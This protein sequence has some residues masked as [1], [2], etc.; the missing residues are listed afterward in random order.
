MMIKDSDLIDDR[1]LESIIWVKKSLKKTFVSLIV[2]FL[3]L[4]IVFPIEKALAGGGFN[5]LVKDVFPKGTMSN[6]TSSAI[7]KEQS[8]GHYIGGSAVIKAPANPPLRPIRARAPSCKLGGM[9]CGAQFE[10]MG[11]ALSLIK[12]QE[13]INYLK[14]LPANAATYGGMMAIKTLCPQCQDLLEYLDAKADELNSISFDH[15]KMNQALIDPLFPKE[16]AKKVALKQSDMLLKGEGQDQGSIQKESKKGDLGQLHQEL[17]SQLGENYNIVWKALEKKLQGTG[18][19]NEFKELLMS[20]SGTIIGTTDAEGKFSLRHVKSLINKDMIREFIGFDGISEDKVKLLSCDE[21]TKC[22]DPKP[23]PQDISQGAFF[24]TRVKDI[25]TGIITKIQND[26]EAFTKEEETFIALSSD[27]IIPRIEHDLALYSKPQSIINNQRIFIEALAFD[28][29][30]NYL[31]ELLVSAQEAVGELSHSQISD[32]E[33]FRD[34]AME[35]REV[36]RML[37][38]ARSEARKKFEQIRDS[39]D[40]LRHEQKVQTQMVEKHVANN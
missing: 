9:P 4:L 3:I 40:K 11:G 32:A 33:K 17:E 37:E 26:N 20:I 13:L 18:S 31:Q 30:T 12:G 6:S 38:N 22:L 28:V 35:T 1:A 5:R 21:T 27:Q 8:A 29:V 16:H 2:L 10:I 14:D 7:V 15:C 24:F 34:F 25:M 36:M 19:D 39:K 23:K